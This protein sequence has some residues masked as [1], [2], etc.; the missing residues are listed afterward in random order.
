MFNFP[1]ATLAH[2]VPSW[3]NHNAGKY[4]YLDQDKRHNPFINVRC[5]NRFWSHTFEVKET[6]SKGRRQERR[7][8]VHR[9]QD[10][11]PHHVDAQSFSHWR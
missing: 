6:E 11:K 9:N 5:T 2:A 1:M 10:R 4:E 8:Q 3:E 7:L